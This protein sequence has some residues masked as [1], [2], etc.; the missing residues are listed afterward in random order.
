M[1]LNLTV[2]S[3]LQGNPSEPR[4]AL[5]ATEC[6]AARGCSD[7]GVPHLR[8]HMHDSVYALLWRPV[9]VRRDVVGHAD[10]AIRVRCRLSLRRRSWNLRMT[11]SAS[12]GLVSRHV[13][14]SR[15][16]R[17]AVVGP[18]TFQHR[19]PCDAGVRGRP[20]RGGPKVV[21]T[22]RVGHLGQDQIQLTDRMT[23]SSESLID[24]MSPTRFPSS[25]F[26]IGEMCGNHPSAASASSSPTIRNDCV[27]PLLPSKGNLPSE[28]DEIGLAR[29]FEQLGAR[30]TCR[31]I[32]QVPRGARH[33]APIGFNG[34]RLRQGDGVFCRRECSIEFRQTTRRDDIGMW[35]DRPLGEKA[36]AA[37]LSSSLVKATLIGPF[38]GAEVGG[39]C[40]R[41]DRWRRTA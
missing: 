26:A 23:S 29:R 1:R 27:R 28:R 19:R 32:S 16:L 13:A 37:S 34:V 2:I 22:D 30:P 39:I 10:L 33:R 3:G 41:T 18:G 35:W 17:A 21:K 38:S 36:A 5:R 15:R 31:E 12:A 25:A 9:G 7:S 14:S 11:S 20:S 24:V 6:R 40:T 4:C 8:R